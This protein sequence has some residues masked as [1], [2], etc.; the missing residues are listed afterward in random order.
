MKRILL[1]LVL[2]L[3]ACSAEATPRTPVL[4]PWRV[5]AA[6]PMDM[7]RT[8]AVS[9]A[10]CR[11][12]LRVT[13]TGPLLRIRLSNSRSATPLTIRSATVGLQS[14][15]A[16]ARAGSLRPLTVGGRTSFTVP[17]GKEAETEPVALPVTAGADVLVSFAVGGTATLTAHRFGAATGWCSRPGSGDLSGS[18]GPAGFVQASRQGLVVEQVEVE[19]A[20]SRPAVVAAGDSLT[21]APLQPGA[22]PRWTQVLA[23]RLPG[24]PVV[25]AAIAGNRVLLGNGYGAPLVR[26]FDHDVLQRRGAGTV[27]VLAGTNDLSMGISAARLQREYAGLAKRARAAGLRVVLVTLPPAKQRSPQAISARKAV[28]RWILTSRVADEV[29]DADRLLRDPSGAERLAPAYDVGD[30]LHLSVA[31]HRVLGE[32]IADALR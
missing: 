17:P 9:D 1:A 16:A 20:A 30:G 27:V 15:G 13:A 3:P 4:E 28:N 6:Q 12:V 10:T 24:T 8:P 7:V 29:V 32:R 26:R 2:V 19:A 21:D 22:G 23:E 18:E 11:Q 25:N 14:A 5:A 31:A